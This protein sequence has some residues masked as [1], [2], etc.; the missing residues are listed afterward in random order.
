MARPPNGNT[1]AAPSYTQAPQT[2][3][4][5]A[6]AEDVTDLDDLLAFNQQAHYNPAFGQGVPVGAE[7]QE[8]FDESATELDRAH[9]ANDLEELQRLARDGL[10]SGSDPRHYPQHYNQ[11]PLA[12]SFDLGPP[13]LSPEAVVDK[14]YAVRRGNPP[15]KYPSH[16]VARSW[17]VQGVF[18]AAQGRGNQ[19]CSGYQAKGSISRE[20]A[21]SIEHAE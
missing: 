2:R 19:S 10:D 17:S 3:T 21:A 18:R 15:G 4:D 8:G 1:Y 14:I 6:A 5:F 9:L 13:Q 7:A 11:P 12:A 16:S 20:Y